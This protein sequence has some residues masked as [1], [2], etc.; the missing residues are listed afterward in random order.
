MIIRDA[1]FLYRANK[2][3]SHQEVNMG[4]DKKQM[5]SFFI[6]SLVRGGL[7]N[8]SNILF[9]KQDIEAKQHNIKLYATQQNLLYKCFYMYK[10]CKLFCQQQ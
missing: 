9:T 4:K 6:G 7:R 8:A 2:P 1:L 10:F 5:S 3:G